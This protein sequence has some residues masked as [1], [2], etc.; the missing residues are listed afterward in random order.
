MHGAVVIWL[1]IGFELRYIYHEEPNSADSRPTNL[2]IIRNTEIAH[3]LVLKSR[4]LE[5]LN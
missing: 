2:S 5:G 4:N 3:Q 1:I